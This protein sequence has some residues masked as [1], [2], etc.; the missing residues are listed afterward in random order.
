MAISSLSTSSMVSGVK[1]RKIWDQLATTDGFFQIAT[2]TLNVAAASIEFTSIPSTYTHLQIRTLHRVTS[3]GL[4]NL[5]IRVN[6]DTANNYSLHYLFGDGSTVSSNGLANT[7]LNTLART[8]GTT[9]TANSFGVA[10]IDILDYANTNKYK[11]F[12]SIT[13]FD[14]N[15]SGEVFLSSANW[16]STNA[17]TSIKITDQG[18]G[19]LAQYSSFALYGVMA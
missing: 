5:T 12:R 7:N 15:G 19:N 1:R 8:P 17:I 2:T 13:G 9:Q 16:R 10:V 14:G 3:S 4:T 18:A 6:S 11:T